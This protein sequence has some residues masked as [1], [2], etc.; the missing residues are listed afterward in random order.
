MAPIKPNSL[1]KAGQAKTDWWRQMAME[2]LA[3]LEKGRVEPGD[4]ATAAA[5]L[6]ELIRLLENTLRAA[7]QVEAR[8]PNKP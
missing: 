7:G 1:P 5:I 8:A 2:Y 4:Q 3:K 6:G